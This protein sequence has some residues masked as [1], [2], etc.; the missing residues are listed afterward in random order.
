MQRAKNGQPVFGDSGRCE[1]CR[2]SVS[3]VPF[4]DHGLCARCL[5]KALVGTRKTGVCCRCKGLIA[6]FNARY[7]WCPSCTL[8]ITRAST[9]RIVGLGPAKIES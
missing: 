2:V 7:L 4:S 8:M 5:R 6:D 1:T 3:G 9:D